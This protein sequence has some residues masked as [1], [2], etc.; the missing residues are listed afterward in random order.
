M[1]DPIYSMV[2]DEYKS[3]WWIC[4]PDGEKVWGPY[5]TSRGARSELT[6][7]KKVK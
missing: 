6:K 4:C 5:K 3:G 7:L 1:I 2:V